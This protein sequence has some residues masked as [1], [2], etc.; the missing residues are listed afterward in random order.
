MTF[1]KLPAL[2][3]LAVAL[4]FFGLPAPAL[5]TDLPGKPL[6]VPS[7]QKVY[8]HDVITGARGAH[9]LTYRF[10]FVAPDLANLV[11]LAAAAPMES[12]TDE[13]MAALDELAATEGGA[14]IILSD[15]LGEGLIT[16]SELDQTPIITI[17]DVPDADQ[18]GTSATGDFVLPP[19]PDSLLRDPM[20]DDIVWLCENFVLPRIASPA[21]RPTEIVISLSDR[22]P[23]STGLEPGA[24]QLF[25]AFSLPADR[26]ECV[27]QPF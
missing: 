16:S 21:P 24:V 13:D 8:W 7:G 14:A 27:W 19:A 18:P 26:N 6:A 1:A 11:P 20:H 22:T 25:E 5:A 12:L 2:T 10:R 3:P 4:L 9:G 17:H 23:D 15:A